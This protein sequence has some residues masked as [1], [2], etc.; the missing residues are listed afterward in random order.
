MISCFILFVSR[1]QFIV[2]IWVYASV[3]IKHVSR[4]NFAQQMDFENKTKL[5]NDYVLSIKTRVETKS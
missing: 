4:P 3:G 2:V 5:I 1:T